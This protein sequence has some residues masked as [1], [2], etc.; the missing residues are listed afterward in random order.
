MSATTIDRR[1]DDGILSKRIERSLLYRLKLRL[2]FSGW[3]QFLIITVPSLVLLL[4]AALVA[5]LVR[6]P[7]AFFWVPF[8]PGA[9]LLTRVVYEIATVKLH[10]HPA[11]AI[12]EGRRGLDAFDLM[13][14]RRSCRSFQVQHLT[15]AHREELTALAQAQT[16]PERMLGTQP[17]RLEYIAA[18]LTVWPTLGGQEF[19]V[20]I[21]PKIYDRLAVIDI[22]RG[23]QTVV[24]QATRM[25]IGT[26]WIGPGAD[27]RSVIAHLGDRFD[28]ARDHVICV[29]AVGYPSRYLPLM[30]R[31]MNLGMHRRLPLSSLFFSDATFTTPLDVSVAPF[32]KWGRCYEA[33][34][35]S[36]SS[37]N[38]QTTRC[39]A[40]TDANGAATRFDF[41]AATTSRYY[42]AVALGIWC[43]NWE[44]GCEAL[45][46]KGHF[47]VLTPEQRGLPH[48]PQLPTYHV[49]WVVED[50]AGRP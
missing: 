40:V 18:P 31:L 49:S 32:S 37:Y 27:Q 50:V 17:I 34:Q 47:E 8:V 3:L 20:A 35:W 16:P 30:V 14:A 25:G 28:P 10:L 5:L 46:L 45:D 43:A 44:T 9:A 38:S 11:E 22:G 26:C 42:A 41:A 12:P 7:G 1:P 24:L 33:C 15:D 19:F 13:R 2:Q 21:A 6:Q 29:C 4:V 23:L 36:P 48:P 39:A